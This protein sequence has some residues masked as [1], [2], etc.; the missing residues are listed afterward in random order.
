MLRVRATSY[1]TRGGSSPELLVF[2]YLDGAMGGVQLPGGGVEADER[3]D[4]A[5]IR[6]AVEET[7]VQ[8]DLELAGLVGLKQ[9]TW[10]SGQRYIDLFFHLRT[11]EPRQV[12]THRMIG[13]P[14]AWDTGLMVE[15]R[16]EPLGEAAR[17]LMDSGYG[18]DAFLRRLQPDG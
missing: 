8:E 10:E 15:A 17:L 4:V 3:P 7:G 11:R 9:S 14:K 16:F 13:H 2:R 5:A 6:E 18:Q 1:V 12:W